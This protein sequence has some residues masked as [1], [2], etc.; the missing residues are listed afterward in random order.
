MLKFVLIGIGIIATTGIIIWNLWQVVLLRIK[1]FLQGEEQLQRV[2]GY[3]DAEV[4][5]EEA[6]SER[7]KTLIS[8]M[9]IT[10]LLVLMTILY[11]PITRAVFINN[12]EH[13]YVESVIKVTTCVEEGILQYKCHYC[14]EKYEESIPLIAHEY[15][16]TGQQ[17]P[18]CIQ[19]GAIIYTCKLCRDVKTEAIPLIDHQYAETSHTASTCV[20][21]G[22]IVYTCEM[23]KDTYMKTIPVVEHTYVE[24]ERDEPNCSNAGQVIFRCEFCGR[25]KSET[26][27]ANEAHQYQYVKECSVKRSFWKNG[28]DNFVCKICNSQYYQLN[29]LSWFFVISAVILMAILLVITYLFGYK[30]DLEDTIKN[31]ILWICAAAI[32]VLGALHELVCSRQLQELCGSQNYSLKVEGF[33]WLC[34]I[35]LLLIFIILIIALN[36]SY[37][38]GDD[39]NTLVPHYKQSH[40]FAVLLGMIVLIAVIYAIFLRKITVYVQTDIKAHLQEN[41]FVQQTQTTLIDSKAVDIAWAEASS[42]RITEGHTIPI[43][44][45]YD[46]DLDTCWQ[47]GVDGDGE[48]EILTYYFEHP[49]YVVGMD[50]VNGRVITENKYYENNRIRSM[51]LYYLRDGDVTATVPLK[52]IEDVYSREAQYHTLAPDKKDEAYYCDAIKIVVDSVYKGSLYKDLCLTEIRFYERVYK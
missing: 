39:A 8:G 35:G 47:D 51:T 50:I 30:G 52:D 43:A 10:I 25:E 24:A 12:H 17:D 28:Y 9:V 49:C 2:A 42:E 3:A 41:D 29:R 31:P 26:L 37:A 19:E 6:R 21:Q 48:G 15:E 46:G 4:K 33:N 5:I 44:D 16:E 32:F 11:F 45:T 14:D 18:T 22:T 23:C 38:I 36:F 20:E 40:I 13:I 27:P 7:K 34:G 1:F